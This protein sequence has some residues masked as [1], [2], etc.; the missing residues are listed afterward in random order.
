VGP[1][2]QE[3]SLETLINQI[4]DGVDWRTRAYLYTGICD[5]LNFGI[6]DSTGKSEGIDSHPQYSSRFMM[7]L[8]YGDAKTLPVEEVGGR[9]TGG[10]ATDYGHSFRPPRPL[11]ARQ[12]R[13]PL[14]QLAVG[15]KPFDIA[16]RHGLIQRTAPAGV[17]AGMVTDAPAYARQGIVLPYYIKG[18][19]KT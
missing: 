8:K 16:D 5:S 15:K 3:N 14:R 10:T 12:P 11:G 1:G 9:K 6:Q 17:L 7:G 4:P 19:I 13:L 2:A 18:L